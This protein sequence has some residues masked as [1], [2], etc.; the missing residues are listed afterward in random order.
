MRYKLMIMLM[1]IT[2]VTVVIGIY[3][4]IGLIVSRTQPYVLLYIMTLVQSDIN[5]LKSRLLKALHLGR[6]G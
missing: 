5:T 1:I 2:V 4:L 3:V 6:K